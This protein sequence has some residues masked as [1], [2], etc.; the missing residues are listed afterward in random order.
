MRRY[1]A[2]PKRTRHKYLWPIACMQMGFE[3]HAAPSFRRHFGGP[4]AL[5]AN[6]P[7]WRSQCGGGRRQRRRE[8]RGYRARDR[9]GPVDNEVD[10]GVVTVSRW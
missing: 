2:M 8:R 3:R 6:E 9:L 10:I 5:G 7:R 1:L 4:P